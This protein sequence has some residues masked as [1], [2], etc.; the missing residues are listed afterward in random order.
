MS[1]LLGEAN[2]LPQSQGAT[3]PLWHSISGF[4]SGTARGKMGLA[5]FSG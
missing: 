5:G 3:E 2:V 4:S 1:M